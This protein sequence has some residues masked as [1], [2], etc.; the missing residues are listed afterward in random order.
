MGWGLGGVAQ[1]Q[2]VRRLLT[3]LLQLS[4][5]CLQSSVSSL[6]CASFSL[7]SHCSC[8]GNV[9][10]ERGCH[11]RAS[12]GYRGVLVKSLSRCPSCQLNFLSLPLG[13]SGPHGVFPCW[14]PSCPGWNFAQALGLTSWLPRSPALLL[15]SQPWLPQLHELQH[16]TNTPQHHS[17]MSQTL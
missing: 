17:A 16:S 15:T 7:P 3:S 2:E 6:P 12:I 5:L 14:V 10:S 8:P 9:V 11:R 4:L 13:T 1:P